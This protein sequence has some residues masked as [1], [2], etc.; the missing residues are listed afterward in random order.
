MRRRALASVVVVCAIGAVTLRLFRVVHGG[1]PHLHR[2]SPPRTAAATVTAPTRGALPA[3]P[4]PRPPEYVERH[5][6]VVLPWETE[7]APSPT[8]FQPTPRPAP[9]P[10][11]SIPGC[12]VITWSSGMSP[13]SI[14]QVLV[15]V[16]AEN[17]CG[18]DLDGM[19]VWFEVAGYRH[20]DLIQVTR[21]HLFDPLPRDGDGTARIALPGSAD[22]YDAIEVAVLPPTEL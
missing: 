3:P 18:R 22:W 1:Q 7:P 13:T 20:G 17:R 10:A 9:T 21:G 5:A 4:N 19:D 12:V 15:E 16:H 8:A 11:P 14:A 2:R 6:T